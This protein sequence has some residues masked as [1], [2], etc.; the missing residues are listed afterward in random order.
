MCFTIAGK[1]T[2]THAQ[3]ARRR[4]AY[5]VVRPEPY[6]HS[7]VECRSYTNEHR[8]RGHAVYKLGVQSTMRGLSADHLA[9]RDHDGGSAAGFYVYRSFM[10][11]RLERMSGQVVIAVKVKPSDLLH[12]SRSG[13]VATYRALTPVREYDR[14]GAVKQ[15]A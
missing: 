2:K 8:H 11:A 15:R 3:F 4:I 6:P 10:Q 13:T 5:K 9:T 1:R 12:V 7:A 14:Y